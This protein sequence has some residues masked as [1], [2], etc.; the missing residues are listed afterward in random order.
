MEDK[1]ELVLDLLE[2]VAI[3]LLMFGLEKGRSIIDLMDSDEIKTI[4]PRIG[5]L[6]DISPQ[7]QKDVW[8]EF[9]QLGYEDQMGPSGALCVI[10]LLFN[11]SKIRDKDKKDYYH[12]GSYRR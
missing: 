7:T 9:E 8:A 4:V 3:F 10:R 6:V 2:K 5:K 11:G 1:G 12:K